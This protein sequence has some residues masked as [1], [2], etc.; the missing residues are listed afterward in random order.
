MCVCRGAYAKNTSARHC[1]KNAGGGAAYVQ[2]GVYLR[3]TTVHVCET[4]RKAMKVGGW[5]HDQLLA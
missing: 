2:R 3:D 5:V 4:S 1:I